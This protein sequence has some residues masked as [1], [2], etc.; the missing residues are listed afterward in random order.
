M[1]R[2]ALPIGDDGK[3]LR[4]SIFSIDRPH[5]RAFHYSWA[6]FQAAFITWLSFPPLM[7]TIQDSLGLPASDVHSSHVAS[8]SSTVFF[9]MVAGM[10]CDWIGPRKTFAIILYTGAV[11]VA[12]GAALINGGPGLIATRFFSGI[13]GGKQSLLVT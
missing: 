2:R 11:P 7:P 3:A 6:G 10:V 12:L 9:R 4:I 5:M 1:V 8:M 13:L